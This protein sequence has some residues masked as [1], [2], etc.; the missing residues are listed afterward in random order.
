M[1]RLNT[2]CTCNSS[3]C[4][5]TSIYIPWA[6][7]RFVSWDPQ[8]SIYSLRFLGKLQNRSCL[9]HILSILICYFLRISVDIKIRTW[10]QKTNKRNVKNSNSILS[11]WAVSHITSDSITMHSMAS[12]VC[13]SVWRTTNSD[14]LNR[15]E[16]PY[17]HR[18]QKS[19]SLVR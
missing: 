18:L 8:Y 4:L 7:S 6:F 13:L 16:V 11:S 10:T 5:G 15:L 3:Y 14:H 19:F 2:S 12:P 17:M 9:L 1:I